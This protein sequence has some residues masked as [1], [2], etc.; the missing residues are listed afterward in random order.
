MSTK[1]ISGRISY[2]GYVGPSINL[3]CIPC[4][5]IVTDIIFESPIDFEVRVTPKGNFAEIHVRRAGYRGHFQRWN[6]IPIL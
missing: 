5:T 2:G 1:R 3:P 6:P 4:R